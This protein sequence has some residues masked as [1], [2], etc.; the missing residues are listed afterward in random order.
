[1]KDSFNMKLSNEIPRIQVNDKTVVNKVVYSYS[2]K[3]EPLNAYFSSIS[4]VD[5]NNVTL[6]HMYNLCSDCLDTCNSH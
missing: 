3:I 5:D 2:D 6:P 1:M 4:N